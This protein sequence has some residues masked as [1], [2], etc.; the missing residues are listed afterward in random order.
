MPPITVRV[1]RQNP[2]ESKGREQRYSVELQPSMTVLDVLHRP[3][4][5]D[6][7]LGNILCSSAHCETVRSGS[8]SKASK[9]PSNTGEIFDVI[10]QVL[11]YEP[12][13]RH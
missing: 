12:Y 2:R 13:L 5:A 10:S 7:F 8:G 11:A 4:S 3:A 6:D 1:H 9:A